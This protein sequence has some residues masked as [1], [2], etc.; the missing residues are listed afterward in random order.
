MKTQQTPTQRLSRNVEM[1]CMNYLIFADAAERGERDGESPL[2]TVNREWRNILTMAAENRYTDAKIAEVLD[3]D[4]EVVH[5]FAKKFK[6]RILED[7]EP[8]PGPVQSGRH[9]VPMHNA[10]TNLFADAAKAGIA[11][12]VVSR[13]IA[14]GD[15][16]AIRQR[17]GL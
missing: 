15:V 10:I 17:I 14:S 13:E 1:M 2:V 16:T 9:L 7:K 8:P 11:E 6:I 3:V 5:R 4:C 12:T